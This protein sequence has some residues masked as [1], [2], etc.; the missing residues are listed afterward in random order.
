MEILQTIGIEI[1]SRVTQIP[2]RENSKILENG[3]IIPSGNQIGVPAPTL[4]TE[5][6]TRTSK[7]DAT[8]QKEGES[9]VGRAIK[10]TSFSSQVALDCSSRAPTYGHSDRPGRPRYD[11]PHTSVPLCVA[12]QW[13]FN[14]EVCSLS[15]YSLM[16]RG[17]ACCMPMLSQ[18][19]GFFLNFQMQ[20]YTETLNSIYQF[21]NSFYYTTPAKYTTKFLQKIR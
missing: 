11:P 12:L 15:P 6:Q 5:T 3:G 14:L 10:L 18:A 7:S 9:L 16:T 20:L 17:C 1:Q 8:A 21:F 13:T 4:S 19:L 2:I